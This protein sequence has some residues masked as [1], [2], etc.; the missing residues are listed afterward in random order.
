MATPGLQLARRTEKSDLGI[1]PSAQQRLQ[2][3]AA[4]V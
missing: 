2:Q 4:T 1:S 3:A